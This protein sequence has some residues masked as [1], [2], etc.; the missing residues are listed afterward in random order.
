[1]NGKTY[2]MQTLIKKA[3]YTIQ[4]SD[5]V[6]L[7]AKKNPERKIDIYNDKYIYQKDI[8]LKEYCHIMFL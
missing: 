6:D 2:S 1:M 4:I 3:G 8:F 7:R 5:K